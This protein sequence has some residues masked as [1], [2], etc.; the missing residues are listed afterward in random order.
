MSLHIVILNHKFGDFEDPC[1]Y[2]M[3]EIADVWKED[4]HTVTVQNGPGPRIDADV[5][6][7]HVDLTIVP[8]DYLSIL[9]QYPK[10]ING[11]ATDISKRTVSRNLV[12]KGD[13]Y[14]GPVI[15]KANRNCAGFKEAELARRGILGQQFL[16]T[17]TQY[18]L[19]NRASEVPDAVWQDRDVVLEKFRPEIRSGFYCLR[20]WVFLGDAETC[21]L[22]YANEPLIKQ[23]SVLH[24]QPIDDVPDDLRELREELGFDF[25]KFDFA[26]H[27]GETVLYDANRTPSLGT[28]SRADFMPRIRKYASGLHSFV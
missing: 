25:G 2:F 28:F 12:S 14:D 5:I 27:E 10:T 8:V 7:N 13:G 16:R 6:V 11:N 24:R 26:I 20:T 9:R 23:R 1:N 22:S 18:Q 17:V 21:S 3:R 19:F 4:G 15:V